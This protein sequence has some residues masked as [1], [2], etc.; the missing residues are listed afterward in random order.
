MMVIRGIPLKRLL[1]IL[2]LPLLGFLLAFFAMEVILRVHFL[3]KVPPY[4]PS[5]T[6]IE[7]NPNGTGFERGVY[8]KINSQGLR[9]YDYPMEK[10]PAIFRIIILGDSVTFGTGVTMEETYA[11]RLEKY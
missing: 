9:D 3:I 5:E 10:A 6:G 4:R 1:T 11:K 7:L 8:V 2:L